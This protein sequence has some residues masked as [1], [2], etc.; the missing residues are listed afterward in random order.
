MAAGAGIVGAEVGIIHA[1]GDLRICLEGPVDGIEVE[2]GGILDVL[3]E[4][5]VGLLLQGFDCGSQGIFCS[6]DFLLCGILPV[7]DFH[8]FR[9]GFLQR[10]DTVFSILALIDLLRVGDG[11]DQ[12]GLVHQSFAGPLKDQGLERKGVALGHT[13]V[14]VDDDILRFDAGI[15]VSEHLSEVLSVGTAIADVGGITVPLDTEPVGACGCQARAGLDAVGIGG[16][17]TVHTQEVLQCAVA[18]ADAGHVLIV[19]SLGAVEAEELIIAV[20]RAGIEVE[21]QSGC[22]GY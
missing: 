11:F 13:G 1:V 16:H 12:R 7:L 9:Q 3:E 22:P 4:E 17:R 5:V 2:L 10:F 14:G 19:L 6:V 15:L 21:F 20:V 18:A 8:G